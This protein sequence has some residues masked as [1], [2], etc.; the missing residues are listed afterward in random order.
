M[1]NQYIPVC[2]FLA[3]DKRNPNSFSWTPEPLVYNA[4]A[5]LYAPRGVRLTTRNGWIAF[6]TGKGKGKLAAKMLYKLR[7]DDEYIANALKCSFAGKRAFVALYHN[8]GSAFPL[9]CIDPHSGKVYWQSEVW[10]VNRRATDAG[11][12]Y[13]NIAILVN[14]ESVAVF[15]QSDECNLEVFDRNTGKALYRFSTNEWGYD[16]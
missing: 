7:I 10:G 4:T 13:Y 12:G 2:D 15:G 6:R 3:R 5:K 1:L 9:L 16:D 11:I 8:R 14:H